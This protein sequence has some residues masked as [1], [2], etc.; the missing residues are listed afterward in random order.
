MARIGDAE[1]SL[2]I[3]KTALTAIMQRYYSFNISGTPKDSAVK[4]SGLVDTFNVFCGKRSTYHQARSRDF[5]LGGV[6]SS[7]C[8]GICGGGYAPPQKIF[9]IL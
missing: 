7:Q 4:F 1:L 9:R 2:K 5:S 3:S 8:G 6:R